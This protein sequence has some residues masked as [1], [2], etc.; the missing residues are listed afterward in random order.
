MYKG[1]TLQRWG[2]RNKSVPPFW[3]FITIFVWRIDSEYRAVKVEVGDEGKLYNDQNL[4]AASK[5]IKK[6][7][8][9]EFSSKY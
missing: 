4:L 3:Y 1:E 9:I 8:L 5:I 6:T 2:L 7:S